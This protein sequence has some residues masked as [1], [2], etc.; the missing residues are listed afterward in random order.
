MKVRNHSCIKQQMLNY[1]VVNNQ[2]F[3]NAYTTKPKS[4]QIGMET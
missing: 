3:Y 2:A 4:D 1:K